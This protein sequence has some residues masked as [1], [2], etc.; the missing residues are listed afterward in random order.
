[1]DTG[2]SDRLSVSSTAEANATSVPRLATR[3]REPSDICDPRGAAR[4]KRFGWIVPKTDRRGD[5]ARSS[6][7][8]EPISCRPSDGSASPKTNPAMSAAIP[9]GIKRIP[10][11]TKNPPSLPSAVPSCRRQPAHRV[12][13]FQPKKTEHCGK[14]SSGGQ[15]FSRQEKAECRRAD[16]GGPSKS[17]RSR[18]DGYHC[19]PDTLHYPVGQQP[20]E[21]WAFS[22]RQ[23]ALPVRKSLPPPVRRPARTVAPP[24]VVARCAEIPMR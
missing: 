8:A 16:R 5:S 22:P 20:S 6:A 18:M 9:A 3:T 1:M 17:G 24:G 12:P 2:G 10:T 4:S 23:P 11:L 15:S 13:H 14:E 21:A 7:S 19:T